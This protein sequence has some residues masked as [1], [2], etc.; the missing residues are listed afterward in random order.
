V[1]APLRGV[2]LALANA[3]D[4]VGVLCIWPVHWLGHYLVGGLPAAIPRLAVG[5]LRCNSGG[6]IQQEPTSN[7]GEVLIPH[8]SNY[9][10]QR[11]CGLFLSTDGS[12]LCI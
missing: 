11:L 8:L 6:M 7:P 10:Y 2:F 3:G 1:A 5:G 9:N 12:D 4:N